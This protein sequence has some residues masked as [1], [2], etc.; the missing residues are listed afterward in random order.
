SPDGKWLVYVSESEDDTEIMQRRI[1]G[2]FSEPAAVAPSAA[3]DDSPALSPDGRWLAWVSTREDVFG[4]IWVVRFPAGE[5]V[6]VSAR[7]AVDSDPRWIRA[8][9]NRLMLTWKSTEH[10]GAISW[11]QVPAGRWA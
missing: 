8:A 3:A 5:P 11:H 4:D 9:D 2:G 7:G 1:D 6:L 10:S